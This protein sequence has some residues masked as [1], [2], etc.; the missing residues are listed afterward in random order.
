MSNRITVK[1]RRKNDRN[2]AVRRAMEKGYKWY[3][4]YRSQARQAMTIVISISQLMYVIVRYLEI[5]N[6]EA[7]NKTKRNRI[8]VGK[9]WW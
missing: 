7:G 2:E 9:R 3:V 4:R 6:T 1:P 5:D 8:T